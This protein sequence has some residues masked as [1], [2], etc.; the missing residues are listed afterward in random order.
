MENQKTPMQQLLEKLQHVKKEMENN[1]TITAEEKCY[2]DCLSSTINDIELQMI[3]I[4]KQCIEKTWNDADA[5]RFHYIANGEAYY[6]QMFIEK[7]TTKH[8]CN[9]HGELLDDGAYAE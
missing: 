1:K 3:P 6:N 5:L 4:E 8:L 9:R 7:D 2:Y